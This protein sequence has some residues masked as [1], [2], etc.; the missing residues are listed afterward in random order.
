MKIRNRLSLQFTIIF[1]IILAVV[2]LVLYLVSEQNRMEDFYSRLKDRALTTAEIYLAEDNFS[3]ARF[4]EVQLKY[5]L[6][7]PHE[8]VR[9]YNYKDQPAF[10][11]DPGMRW[12]E[13]IINRVRARKYYAFASSRQQVVGLLY[14]DNSGEFVVLASAIDDNGFQKMNELLWILVTTYVAALMLVFIIGRIFSTM[15]LSPITRV[16]R[17]MKGIKASDLNRRV[18]QGNSQDEISELAYHFNNLLGNLEKSFKVQQSFVAHASHELRNPVTSILGEMEV[19]LSKN[20][21]GEEYRK[22][23]QFILVE[24]ERLKEITDELLNL[25]Q[26]DFDLRQLPLAEIRID[27]LLFDIWSEWQERTGGKQL[28]LEIK[29]FPEDDQRLLILGNRQVITL[30]LNNVVQNALKFSPSEEPVRCKMEVGSE[31]VSIRIIDRG[32]GIP[33]EDIPEIFHPFFRARNAFSY[34]G[35]GIG[36]SFTER[37]VQIHGGKIEVEST[38]NKG[39]TMTLIFPIHFSNLSIP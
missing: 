2:F 17:Q 34:S 15:A 10:I 30:A 3:K 33:P 24:A 28:E 16:I 9:I 19:T 14:D 8:I 25:T 20:R 1:A 11:P 31:E 26:V 13:R 37:V 23:M 21:L 6:Q 39:T 36:L 22:S 35:H 38:I 4:R 29:E 18:D 27:E 32:I 12:P 5:P 7:L